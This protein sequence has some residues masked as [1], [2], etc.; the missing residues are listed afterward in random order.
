MQ[1]VVEDG[2]RLGRAL[3][4]YNRALEQERGFTDHD[5]PPGIVRE[6]AERAPPELR[7][8]LIFV[9]AAHFRFANRPSA[10]HALASERLNR[11]AAVDL[12]VA[13]FLRPRGKQ[14]SGA[15]IPPFV[16]ETFGVG[17][18]EGRA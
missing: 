18:D 8:P 13:W 15:R 5:C 11:E 10:F 9:G 6:V 12:G 4:L 2:A 1:C 16:K 7:E 14:A 3:D 17:A